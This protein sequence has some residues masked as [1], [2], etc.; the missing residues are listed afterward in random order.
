ME[1]Q[2]YLPVNLLFGPGKVNCLGS[3]AA[4]YGK[5]ALL[6]TGTGSTKRSGL[7]DRAVQLLK[8]A[9]VSCTIFDQVTPNPLT[10]TAMDAAALARK[11]NCDVVIGL[12]G[13][14]IMDAAKAAAFLCTNEGDINDYIFGRL[15]GKN[16]LPILLVP[17]TCGTGSEGNGFAVL[18]N[19][20][21]GDKKS[22]RG[23]FIV[24]K[25][26]IIDPE[27]MKTMPQHVLAS[28]GFDALCHCMEAYLSGIGQP[29]T[30]MMAL[31]GIRL[32]AENLPVVFHS[33]EKDGDDACVAAAWEAVTWASTLGGMVI[34]TAGVAG[35]HGMEHPASGLRNIVHGQGLAALTPVIYEASLEA[36]PEK[37]AVISKL[38]GGK[39]YTDC[40][41]HLYKLLDEI[42]LHIGLSDLGITETDIPW[43]T[44]NC[45]KV[46]VASMKNHPKQ[47]TEEEIAELYRKAL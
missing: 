46:S 16:A 27:L 18:T 22:L 10:T 33:Y 40:V 43:M 41:S 24:A 38:L 17:T 21:T 30:E 2:Y 37:F 36:A 28:V 4:K 1:F 25:A 23:P 6:V 42:G 32:S 15:Q 5:H 11:N 29:M 45:L 35:P 9:S 3:E 7:L 47:F 8:D 13:G 20:E 19:P 34:H 14:S 12:G 31:R 39:G 44:Q 26:S